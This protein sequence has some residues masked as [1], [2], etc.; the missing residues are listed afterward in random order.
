VY[1]LSASWD[2]AVFAWNGSSTSQRGLGS[3]EA[4]ERRNGQVVQLTERRTFTHSCA[5]SGDAGT[6][7]FTEDPARGL[8]FDLTIVD[9][10][11]GAVIPTGLLAK[12]RQV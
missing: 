12:L 10:R 1:S 8:D 7:A 6:L 3:Y 5:I 4:F 11:S 9:L 2:G